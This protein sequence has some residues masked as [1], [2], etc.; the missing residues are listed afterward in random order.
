MA[1]GPSL[2]LKARLR[3]GVD[4]FVNG[5]AAR[6]TFRRA[7]DGSAVLA[8]N[9]NFSP[10]SGNKE[11]RAEP[12]A[13]QVN[14]FNCEMIVGDWNAAYK[15]ELRSFPN[16]KWD[17]QVDASSRAH[18]VLTSPKLPIKIDPRLLEDV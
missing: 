2:L 13:V 18:M 14:N 5:R 12:F 3:S 11:T 8:G 15:E 10:E 16:G 9:V 1:V 17:D 7:I 4:P 6:R